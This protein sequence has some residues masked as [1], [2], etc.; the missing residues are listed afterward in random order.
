MWKPIIPEGAGKKSGVNLGGGDVRESITEDLLL[1]GAEG[2]G[3]K[4]TTG[5]AWSPG[6]TRA[7]GFE[8]QGKQAS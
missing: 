7:S 6:G 3:V 2:R 4:S 8:H 5:T 1:S